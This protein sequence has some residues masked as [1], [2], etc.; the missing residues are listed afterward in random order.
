MITF[1]TSFYAAILGLFFVALSVR[2]LRARRRLQVAIGDGRNEQMLRAMRV[3]ANFAEYVPLTLL[4]IFV[5]E[6]QGG[7]AVV[8]HLLCA[9]LV[10]GRLAHAYGVS[11]TPENFRYRVIGMSLTFFALAG[12]SIG[13]LVAHAWQLV[14]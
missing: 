6:F 10:L 8:V 2:T 9:S 5:L 1:T 14:A 13:L 12:A 11:R 7:H 4:L 3:H